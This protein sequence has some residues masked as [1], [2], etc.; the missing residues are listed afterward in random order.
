MIVKHSDL[1]GLLINHINRYILCLC[2]CMNT[3]RRAAE[4]NLVHVYINLV[5]DY[6]NSHKSVC[7]VFM[8]CIYIRGILKKNYIYNIY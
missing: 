3:V 7:P 8:S 6:T 5:P 4:F 2:T 1:P